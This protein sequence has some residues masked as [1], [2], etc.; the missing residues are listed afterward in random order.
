MPLAQ[1]MET[2]SERTNEDELLGQSDIDDYIPPSQQPKRNFAS[3]GKRP[4]KNNVSQPVI[5]NRRNRCS[6]EPAAEERIDQAERAIKAIKRRMEK[7][8]CPESL[9]YRAR[10]KIWADNDFKL[11]IKRTRKDAEQEVLKALTRFH[12]RGI[13]R[14]RIEI[15]KSKRP[16]ISE[17]SN[18]SKTLTK[19][20]H[21]VSAA[22]NN[23]TIKSVEQ[24]AENIQASI[25]Q[26]SEMMGKLGGTKNKQVEKYTCV[27]SDSHHKHGAI[28]KRSK[29]CIASKK[30]QECK[31]IKQQKRSDIKTEQIRQIWRHPSN[32]TKEFL[33][34]ICKYI[35]MNVCGDSG[36]HKMK[37]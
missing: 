28:G 6:I 33:Q 32:N 15:K 2:S 10:A 11:H 26:F 1:A 34:K 25:A 16:R 30:C 13:N 35:W 17:A 37:S 12:Q 14:Y 21:S 31:K 36:E 20:A 27:F 3:R 9:Q 7:G 23:I 19:T 5:E 24:I 18:P 8:T 22:N 4:F 29:T